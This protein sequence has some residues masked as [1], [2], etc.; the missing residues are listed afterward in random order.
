[1]HSTSSARQLQARNQERASSSLEE[2]EE[3]EL[4]NLCHT[5]AASGLNPM[6]KREKE[7]NSFASQYSLQSTVRVTTERRNVQYCSNPFEC[8]DM[9]PLRPTPTLCLFVFFL[10]AFVLVL[11]LRLLLVIY[12]MATATTTT[13][14]FFFL[15]FYC[16][17][18]GWLNTKVVFHS[19]PSPLFLS[20]SKPNS[21]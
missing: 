8:D 11:L 10:A 18:D 6:T 5:S 20:V 21:I 4:S 14:P 9:V 17:P 15:F 13:L 1:M 2:D 16:P 7:G 12:L 3:L 19:F